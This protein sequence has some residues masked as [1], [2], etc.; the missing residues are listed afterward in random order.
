MNG[1]DRSLDDPSQDAEYTL[2]ILHE[3]PDRRARL[4]DSKIDRIRD[5]FGATIHGRIAFRKW[6]G[7]SG[8]YARSLE[9]G[10]ATLVDPTPPEAKPIP[11]VEADPTPSDQELMEIL[12]MPQADRV[13]LK[14]RWIDRVCDYFCDAKRYTEFFTWIGNETV[15]ASAIQRWYDRNP[16]K[17]VLGPIAMTVEEKEELRDKVTQYVN[18][19]PYNFTY[20][21]NQSMIHAVTNATQSVEIKAII[22]IK[23]QIDQLNLSSQ[24]RVIRYFLDYVGPSRN[25]IDPDD[26]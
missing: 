18:Q 14:P 20:L 10:G 17:P 11:P 4:S 12:Q 26:R 16:S 23:E 13:H 2:D 3:L 22:V 19:H 5:H 7:D 25:G 15:Y 21:N 1:R 9:R 24:R 8:S 6:I